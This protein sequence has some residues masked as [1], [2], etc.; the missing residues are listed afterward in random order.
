[1]S[2]T[3]AVDFMLKQLSEQRMTAANNVLSGRATQDE[4]H[5]LCGV[6]QG[7]DYAKELIETAIKM[8]AQEDDDE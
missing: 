3:T 8:A 7:L 6:I 5:R 4:Y 2:E 1:M